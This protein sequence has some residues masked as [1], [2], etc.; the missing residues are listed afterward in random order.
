MHKISIF[1]AFASLLLPVGVMAQKPAGSHVDVEIKQGVPQ[2]VVRWF[3]LETGKPVY[4][5]P[6]SQQEAMMIIH[7]G[8]QWRGISAPSV[9]GQGTPEFEAALQQQAQRR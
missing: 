6:M 3:A 1:L 4:S 5:S 9:F 8:D 2:V 7:Q